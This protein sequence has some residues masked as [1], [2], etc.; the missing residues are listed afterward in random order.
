M[1]GTLIYINAFYHCLSLHV[2]ELQ[3]SLRCE[4]S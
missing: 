2:C 3:I 4:I 1:Y